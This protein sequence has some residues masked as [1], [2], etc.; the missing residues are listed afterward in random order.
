MQIFQNILSL[1]PN[2]WGFLCDAKPSKS[3]SHNFSR[4]NSEKLI[5]TMLSFKHKKQDIPI[6]Q[7]F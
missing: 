2:H 1:S 4:C 5:W 6:R 3:F 7:H